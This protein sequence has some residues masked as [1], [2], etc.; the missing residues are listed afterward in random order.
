MDI[1]EIKT[2][3]LKHVYGAPLAESE[4]AVVDDYAQTTDGGTYL[5]ECREVKHLLRSVADVQ[6]KPVDHQAMVESFERTVRQSFQQ[7]VLRPWGEAYSGPILLGL[8]ASLLVVADGASV[9][10]SVFLGICVLWLIMTWF[11]R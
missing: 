4:R 1:N 8:L 6:I 9:I 3:C 2:L 7:T 10:S 5:R 11:Q